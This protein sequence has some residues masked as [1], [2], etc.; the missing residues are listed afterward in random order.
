MYIIIYK[1]GSFKGDGYCA[2]FRMYKNKCMYV[3]VWQKYMPFTNMFF[4]IFKIHFKY[5]Y[6]TAKIA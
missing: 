3:N 5:L 6:N 4:I 1:Q 2:L